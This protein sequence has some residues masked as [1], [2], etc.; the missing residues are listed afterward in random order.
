MSAQLMATYYFFAYLILTLVL[1]WWGRR[2]MRAS[3]VQEYYTAGKSVGPWLGMATYGAS[4]FSAFTFLGSVG[5]Y[6]T[7]GLGYAAV[8]IGQM[9]FSG[10]LFPTIGHK[11]WKF[12]RDP[13]VIT[14]T[15]IVARR[16]EEDHLVRALF[17]LANIGFMFFLMGVQVV[18]ISYVVEKVTGGT[19]S[20]TAAA[21][22]V[23]V[24]LIIYQSLGGMRG[25]A[26][27]DV[28]QLGLL[29]LTLMAVLITIFVNF[30]VS[31]LLQRV[32]MSD[33]AAILSAPGPEG[34]WNPTYWITTFIALGFGWFMW[35]H[36]WARIIAS[37]DKGNMWA[38]PIGTMVGKTLFLVV[39][40][41]LVAFV[42]ADLWPTRE[43]LAGF[44]PDQIII[45][46]MLDYMPLPLAALMLAGTAAAAMSTV[47][48]LSLVLSSIA[49]HDLYERVFETKLNE[50]QKTT[51][52]RIVAAF[53][54]AIATLIALNPPTL[55][56][57]FVIN[58]SYAAFSALAPAV[59]F[60]F[61]WSRATTQGAR[62]SLSIGLATALLIIGFWPNP[63]GLNVNNAFWTLTIATVVLVVVSLRTRPVSQEVLRYFELS[64]E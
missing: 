31:A 46:F 56:V 1:G 5:I 27:T 2:N 53:F 24:V 21:L 47:D 16:Y 36:L 15:D 51:R 34:I 64:G 8:P 52:A 35:P 30:D 17:A 40:T 4:N 43:A 26:Y 20:Y 9:F 54:P 13:E 32:A 7:Q 55:I 19:I 11:I 39:I 44:S 45:R 48:S 49:V 10:I 38:I 25:V 12:S 3:T 28:L 61:Y 57:G 41:S 6:Y 33:K 50:A 37:R 14:L 29:S 58:T 59:I 18:G 62:W 42:A 22:T 63:F 60:G 23:A